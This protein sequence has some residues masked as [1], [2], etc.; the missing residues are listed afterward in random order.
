MIGYPDVNIEPEL[1]KLKTRHDEITILKN[2]TEKH[3]YEN[4]LKTLNF[5]TQFYEN[6]NKSLTEKKV[7]LIITEL[8]RGSASTIISSTLAILNPSAGIVISS[9]T[10]L[11]TGIGILIMNECISELKI[12][13]TKLREWINV[14]ALLYEKSQESFM[15]EEETDDKEAEELRKIYNIYLDKIEGIMK[16]ISFKIED[17]LV[18]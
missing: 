1:K 5:D 10:A 8:L 7:L 16:K 13:Y 17:F 9:S 15:I 3:D 6:K 4:I 11:L 2:Q 12:W 18:M 14:I